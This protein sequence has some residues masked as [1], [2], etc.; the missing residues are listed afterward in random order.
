MLRIPGYD[1]PVLPLASDAEVRVGDLVIAVG[2]SSTAPIGFTVV[3]AGVVSV[4]GRAIEAS[5]GVTLFDLIQTDIN[6]TPNHNGAPLVNLAGELVGIIVEAVDGQFGIGFAVGMDTVAPVT[7]QLVELGR[8]RRP[9]LGVSFSASSQEVVVS[10]SGGEST[11]VIRPS[12][13]GEP[14][15][16]KV[17]DG[18]AAAQAGIKPGD[19]LVSLGGYKVA[20]TYDVQRLLRREFKISQEIE[21]VVTRDGETQTF[22]L[23]MGKRPK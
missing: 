19:L 14:I 12:S 17:I 22:Q 2:N 18:G 5:P 21:V 13:P 9:Y 23:I 10:I 7:R 6:A 4:L 1:Y 11:P 16:G 20:N 15:V 3:S 8:V